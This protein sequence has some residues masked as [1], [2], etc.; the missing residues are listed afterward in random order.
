MEKVWIRLDYRV[1]Y[2]LD[3]RLDYRPVLDTVTGVREY[4]KASTKDRP[5]NA[6]RA[7]SDLATIV[8]RPRSD[9]VGFL[10][11]AGL[12]NVIG[13][14]AKLNKNFITNY[15]K[16]ERNRQTGS[17]LPPATRQP[18]SRHVSSP[19]VSEG[20]NLC[21]HRPPDIRPADLSPVDPAE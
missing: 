9:Q 8:Q 14:R 10:Q 19:N 13:L 11:R 7:G 5:P 20:L 17:E 3:Y 1:D 18:S 21:C 2:R 6:M 12:T 15:T 4:G 16:T